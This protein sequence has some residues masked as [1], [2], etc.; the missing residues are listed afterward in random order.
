MIPAYLLNVDKLIKLNS[1]NFLM[2][3]RVMEERVTDLGPVSHADFTRQ[4]QAAGA[5]R[6]R[7]GGFHI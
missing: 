7:L 3:Y 4:L 6:L 5:D 1:N 2:S